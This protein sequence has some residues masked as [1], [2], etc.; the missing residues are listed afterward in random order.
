[1]WVCA[2]AAQ[3]EGNAAVPIEQPWWVVSKWEVIAQCHPAV[4]NLLGQRL[5]QFAGSSAEFRSTEG[6]RRK[7]LDQQQAAGAATQAI[8]AGP[9]SQ[10][11][12]QGLLQPPIE[13]GYFGET[14]AVQSHGSQQG[15]RRTMTPRLPDGG[16]LIALPARGSSVQPVSMVVKPVQLVRDGPSNGQSDRV[17]HGNGCV[18]TDSPQCGGNPRGAMGPACEPWYLRIRIGP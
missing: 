12:R 17:P 9:G 13:V 2:R 18:V 5:S 1:V 14:V 3:C 15:A 7:L 6:F 11:R 10:R 4:A 8:D 16:W